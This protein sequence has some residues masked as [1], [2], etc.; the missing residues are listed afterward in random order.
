[1]LLGL[2]IGANTIFHVEWALPVQSSFRFNE[3]QKIFLFKVFEAGEKTGN[4]S[5]PEEVNQLM[6]N[7][8]QKIIALLS[9]FN[10]C[11]QDGQYKSVNQVY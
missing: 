10:I 1:M 8:L 2:R 6:Q 4:K 3:D 9:K 11:F 7:L 5:K